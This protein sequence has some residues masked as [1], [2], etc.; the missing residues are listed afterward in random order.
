MDTRKTTPWLR[1]LRVLDLRAISLMTA[2]E[3]IQKK[4]H[5]SPQSWADAAEWY[6]CTLD[7]EEFQKLL[8]FNGGRPSSGWQ[9]YSDGSYEIRDVAVCVRESNR[10]KEEL[11][12]GENGS[13]V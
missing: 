4:C 2:R 10:R 12:M 1:V 8:V 9:E 6:V 5:V 7:A 13:C 3:L 11:V